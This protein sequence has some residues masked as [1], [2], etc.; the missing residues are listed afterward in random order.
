M[1]T[2]VKMAEATAE[3]DVNA[4]NISTLDVFGLSGPTFT[5]TNPEM[6]L[7]FPAIYGLFMEGITYRY[8]YS[9]IEL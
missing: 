5:Y 3:T 8:F 4:G 2:K 1:L 9:L 6:M 7:S